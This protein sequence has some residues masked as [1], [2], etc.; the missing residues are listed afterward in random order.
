M[1]LKTIICLINS[2]ILLLA[3]NLCYCCLPSGPSYAIA[4]IICDV[5]IMSK[6]IQILYGLP[7]EKPV[8]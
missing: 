3:I 1:I 7:K 5:S 2:P 6:L 8:G 4:I